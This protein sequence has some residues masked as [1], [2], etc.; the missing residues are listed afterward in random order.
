MWR[1]CAVA[2]T[3]RVTNESAKKARKS[4]QIYLKRDV[5]QTILQKNEEKFA[6]LFESK[7][8]S[9]DSAKKTRKSLQIYLKVRVLQTILQK[10][11]QKVCR[12]S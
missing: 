4:L 11:R 1:K 10:N 7:S 3:G 2:A 6:D 12:I 8:S 5:F 9:N